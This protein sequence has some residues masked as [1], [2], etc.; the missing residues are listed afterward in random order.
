[1]AIKTNKLIPSIIQKF[2][3]SLN[4][5]VCRKNEKKNFFNYWLKILQEQSIGFWEINFNCPFISMRP[6]YLQTNKKHTH[7][8]HTCIC[9]YEYYNCTAWT[10]AN[11]RTKIIIFTRSV[12]ARLQRKEKQKKYVWVWKTTHTHICVHGMDACMHDA[13]VYILWNFISFSSF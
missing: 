13:V 4:V 3:H 12:T 5:V 7:T 6:L 9:A 8:T 10:S 11:K 2:L 1:M